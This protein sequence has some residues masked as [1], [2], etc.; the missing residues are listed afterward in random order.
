MRQESNI[1]IRLA[2][3]DDFESIYQIWMEGIGSSFD[4]QDK[5]DDALKDKF[6]SV[7]LNRKG[8]FNY[9]VAVNI[10]GDVLGWQSLNKSTVNPIKENHLAESSTYITTSARNSG[11]GELLLGHVIK[12]AKETEIRYII[13]EIRDTNTLSRAMVA[14]LGFTEI[15][16]FPENSKSDIS[17]IFTVLPL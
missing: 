4:I 9:W 14:K 15:G 12:L 3:D 17:N 8:I 2:I 16:K 1:A 6:K 5:K 7:F 10:K 11:I 13:G